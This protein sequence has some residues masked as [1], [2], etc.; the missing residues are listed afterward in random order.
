TVLNAY[1]TPGVYSYL[2]RMQDGLRAKGYGGPVTVMHSAGGVSSV[3]E[4]RDRAVALLSSGPVGGMLG[5]KSLAERLEL[6]DVI[7]TDV[8]GTSFD[9][10][11]IVDGEP[12]YATTPVFGK[13]PV[14][15]PVIDVT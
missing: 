3:E 11:L 4:A 8:G 2:E 9:V 1:L 10:G 15:L 12:S 5:A 7:A 6:S 13:Y 14:A